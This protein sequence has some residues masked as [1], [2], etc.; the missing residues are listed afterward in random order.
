MVPRLHRH[1]AG[2][3]EVEKRAWS[4]PR[5][6]DRRPG[7]RRARAAVPVAPRQDRRDAAGPRRRRQS[8]YHQDRKGGHQ[9]RV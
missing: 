1:A 9:T 4:A 3:D 8:R 2:A 7:A 5:T 6:R